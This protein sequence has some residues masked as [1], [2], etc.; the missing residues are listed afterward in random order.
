MH[1]EWATRDLHATKQNQG[2]SPSVG[3]DSQSLE[4]EDLAKSMLSENLKFLEQ[5]NQAQAA[6]I[7]ALLGDFNR[8]FKT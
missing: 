2:I 3:V 8:H 7:K 1:Q 4:N 5:L 6:K